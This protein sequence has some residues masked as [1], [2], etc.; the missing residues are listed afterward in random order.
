MN[1]SDP[2][3]FKRYPGSAWSR[4][5]TLLLLLIHPLPYILD[6]GR[7]QSRKPIIAEERKMEHILRIFDS[8]FL[9]AYYTD[10]N[11]FS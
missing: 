8:L 9:F 2:R 7:E 4:L 6:Y 3:S 11:C 5:L 1:S 10:Y